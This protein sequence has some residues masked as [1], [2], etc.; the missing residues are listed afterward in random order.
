MKAGDHGLD[1]YRVRFE[2]T[3]H[4]KWVDDYPWIGGPSLQSRQVR[5]RKSNSLIGEWRV[6]KEQV[7]V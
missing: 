2:M 1:N 7:R 5:I 3:H 6:S 4:P